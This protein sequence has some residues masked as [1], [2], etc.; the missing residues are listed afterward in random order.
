MKAGICES[1]QEVA[2]AVAAGETSRVA[3]GNFLAFLKPE[4]VQEAIQDAPTLLTGLLIHGP[5]T[6]AYLAAVAEFLALKH[7]LLVP[8]WTEDPARFLDHLHFP[9]HNKHLNDLLLQETPEPFRRRGIVV[10]ANP[11]DVG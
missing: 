4:C 11:L 2:T 3:L 5:A 10:S 8:T 1:L 9:S 7:G 6:D